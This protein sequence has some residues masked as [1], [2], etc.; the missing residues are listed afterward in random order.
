MTRS[1]SRD[2]QAEH[3][4]GALSSVSLGSVS[5]IGVGKNEIFEKVGGVN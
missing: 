1:G 4:G 5:T 3:R 2:Q